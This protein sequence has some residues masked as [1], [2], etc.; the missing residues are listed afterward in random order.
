MEPRNDFTDDQKKV[1][2]EVT[3]ELED[4]LLDHVRKAHAEAREKLAAAGV[5]VDP[6]GSYCHICLNSAHPC[7]SYVPGFSAQCKRY[8]C[9]HSSLF[10]NHPC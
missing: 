3:A 10:H 6:D 8:T 5:H 1:I 9:H 7:D 2:D 4:L